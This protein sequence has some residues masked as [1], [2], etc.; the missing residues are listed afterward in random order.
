MVGQVGQTTS[1]IYEDLVDLEHSVDP[2]YRA[3]AEFMFHDDTLKVLK[4]L[5]D[6]DGRPLWLPGVAVREPDTILGYN[7]VIN[8]DMPIMAANAKS[9]LFGDFSKYMIRDVMD[10]MLLRLVERYA[11]FA[12]VG[13]IAFSRHDGD[14]LDAGTNPIKHY[15]NS[16][17]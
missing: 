13:F 5:K 14:L 9:I 3:E 12:Q 4:K 8:Q 1:V 10:L 15:A 16:A 7:Y 11:D 2:A 6:A 17:T